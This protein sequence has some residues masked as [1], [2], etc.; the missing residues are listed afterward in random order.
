M[1]SDYEIHLINV[2]A[3]IYYCHQYIFHCMRT[4]MAQENLR[5]RS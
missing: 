5:K 1:S 4:T 2:H 3:L